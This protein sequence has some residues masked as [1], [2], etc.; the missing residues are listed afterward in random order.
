MQ[1]LIC[2]S[3]VAPG[4]HLFHLVFQ[5]R[6]NCALQVPLGNL[7]AIHISGMTNDFI[8]KQSWTNG[9]P[10]TRITPSF[11]GNTSGLRGSIFLSFTVFPWRLIKQQLLLLPS[12][13]FFI[14]LMREEMLD[15][16]CHM[17]FTTVH[18][19]KCSIW[20][21]PCVFFSLAP[22]FINTNKRCTGTSLVSDGCFN[23][24][25][26]RKSFQNVNVS[27][28]TIPPS[29]TVKVMLELTHLVPMYWSQYFLN[30][31]TGRDFNIYCY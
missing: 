19:V 24:R 7:S 11:L 5:R 2:C 3:K 28:V 21:L 25:R 20:S 30:P 29:S 26:N 4:S 27:Q 6:R 23:S 15:F 22:A 31:E 10:D 9:A 18:R 14:S 13:F 8:V 16:I 17:F 1:L 12:T